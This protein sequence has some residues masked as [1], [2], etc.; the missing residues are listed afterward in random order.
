[1]RQTLCFV[2]TAQ[3]FGGSI[4][5]ILAAFRRTIAAFKSI[6]TKQSMLLTQPASL[7]LALMNKEKRIYATAAFC[8]VSPSACL[9]NSLPA[10]LPASLPASALVQV[11]PGLRPHSPSQLLNST[12]WL[13]LMLPTC[14]YYRLRE[15]A[16]AA[17]AAAGQQSNKRAETPCKKFANHRET[18]YSWVQDSNDKMSNESR[19][20]STW[21]RVSRDHEVVTLLV[22]AAKILA[23]YFVRGTRRFIDEMT[24]GKI[25]SSIDK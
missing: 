4:F 23:F 14:C 15:A 2:W 20:A 21:I 16:A 12:A 1:M 10:C 13:L 3:R 19:M 18:G 11:R 8:K 25:A 24:E 6:L 9:P 17:A 7:V 22:L 5:L